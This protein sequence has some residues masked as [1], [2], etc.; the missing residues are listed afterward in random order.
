MAH[1]KT[2]LEF[3]REIKESVFHDPRDNFK[4]ARVH[5]EVRRDPLTGETA[6]I[7]HFTL[8]QAPT[9]DDS[10]FV[11]A[12][13]G[14]PFCPPMVESLTPKFAEDLV[15]GGR[16]KRGEAVLF[17]NLF[18]YDDCS[19]VIALCR[20]HF[21]PMGD[22]PKQVI[23]DSFGAALEFLNLHERLKATDGKTRT[24]VVFWN[25]LPPSG[26]SQPHP[27][28]H[29]ELTS[30]PSTGVERL[31]AAEKAYFA[32]HG[33]PYLS[34]LLAHE[35]RDGARWIGEHGDI[36][37]LC[38]FAPRGLMGDC[39]AVFPGKKVLT[40]LSAADLDDFAVG[41]RRVLGAFA[42]RNLRA[43]NLA[44]FASPFGEDAPHH[45]LCARLVPRFH[46]NPQ[47]HVSDA[48]VVRMILDESVT[49]LYPEDNARSHRRA[50]ESEEVSTR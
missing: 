24:G 45:Q 36:S 34:D 21:Q 35:K 26:G 10:P 49:M 7:C 25:H 4:L 19:S 40:D 9:Y 47:I 46:V 13:D 6:R 1:D 33:R 5:S 50:W 31:L 11:E 42:A 48:A 15:P 28:M 18:P 29:A 17:P 3:F 2:G 32:T 27:H 37:W 43:F 39:M 38:P 23:V 41:L 30:T 16:I 12:P 44:F 8:D 20:A 22:I 14:C